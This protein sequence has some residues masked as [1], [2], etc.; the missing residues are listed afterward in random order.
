MP[1]I[2]ERKSP[3]GFLKVQ[4]SSMGPFLQ[5]ISP[6]SCQSGFNPVEWEFCLEGRDLE[7]KKKTENVFLGKGIRRGRNLGADLGR[8]QWNNSKH[9]IMLGV[10]PGRT[11]ACPIGSG[12]AKN[13]WHIF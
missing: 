8:S 6:F 9:F 11:G 7:K 4:S 13:S 3:P 2:L 10:N 12:V 5:P 1:T